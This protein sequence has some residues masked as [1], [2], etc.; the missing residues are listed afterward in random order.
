M[1]LICVACNKVIVVSDSPDHL[2]GCG[3]CNINEEQG[4]L[5]LKSSAEYHKKLTEVKK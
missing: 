5:I 2:G 3:V 1:S 4:K